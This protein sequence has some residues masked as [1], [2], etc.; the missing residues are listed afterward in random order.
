[1]HDSDSED[2][3][4]E[5]RGNGMNTRV[6]LDQ[7]GGCLKHGSLDEMDKARS[8]AAVAMAIQ[9]QMTAAAMSGLLGGTTTP[10]TPSLP[11]TSP[12]GALSINAAAAVPPTT[13]VLSSSSPGAGS[14]SSG[15]GNSGSHLEA[16]KGYTFEEQFK[17]VRL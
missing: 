14:G 12:V 8:R 13:Q 17:Q 3:E 11:P 10:W 7:L 6:K 9:Q 5:A 1:M 16:S 15:S 4:L 2:E